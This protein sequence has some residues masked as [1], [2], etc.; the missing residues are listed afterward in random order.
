MR[1]FTAKMFLIVIFLYLSFGCLT[2]FPNKN[3]LPNHGGTACGLDGSNCEFKLD[4]E[5][6]VST[7]FT[8]MWD[9]V[10]PSALALTTSSTLLALFYIFGILARNMNIINYV[11]QEL[12]ELVISAL[13]LVIVLGSVFSLSTI[14]IGSMLPS[15]FFPK[16]AGPYAGVKDTDSV[17]TIT[18]NFFQLGGFYVGSW[19]DM[20]YVM[21]VVV[22]QFASVPPY[23]RPLGVGLVATPFAGFFSPIKQ[24]L[25]NMSVALSVAYIIMYAQLFA[26]VFSLQ[27][28]LHYYLPAGLFLR[29]FTPT[30]RL[31]GT[32]IGLSAAF[33]LVFPMITT[34]TFS[35]LL[36]G[37]GTNS[38]SSWS[39]FLKNYFTTAPIAGVCDNQVQTCNFLDY[40][41][42]F[43]S[44][45]FS[46]TGASDVVS[47]TY[48]SVG[49]ALQKLVGSFFTVILLAPISIISLAFLIAFLVPAFNLLVFVEAA[50]RFSAIFGEEVDISSLTRMI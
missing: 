9:W 17:Y 43:F 34:V 13:L 49:T 14:T 27:A 46:D 32:L 20:S 35:V 45:R 11:R 26:Y 10:A 40:A 7:S 12:L 3:P 18:A 16:A 4:A 24:L 1:L 25:Y 23:A 21:N 38:I 19:L 5:T 47:A 15:D 50:K 44:T 39:N 28:F 31:G 8:G 6:I 2:E 48:G 33:L 22:D 36:S 37:I 41:K 42:N 30:R 29:C